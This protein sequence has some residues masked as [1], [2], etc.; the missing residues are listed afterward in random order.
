M[1]RRYDD[2]YVD[3]TDTGIALHSAGIG[4]LLALRIKANV[5]DNSAGLLTYADL[6]TAH[7]LNHCMTFFNFRGMPVAYV[8]WGLLAADVEASLMHSG[9]HS[10]HHSEWNEGTSL[11]IIEVCAP[12]NNARKALRTACKM[13][14]PGGGDLTCVRTRRGVITTARLNL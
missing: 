4:Y 6:V 14:L 1:Q 12:Y 3:T 8:V 2:L 10:F 5:A 13:L 9:R 7:R 11:W